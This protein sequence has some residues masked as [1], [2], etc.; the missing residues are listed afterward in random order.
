MKEY[1]HLKI[2]KKWQKEWAK[3]KVYQTKDLSKKPKFYVL[4]MFPYVSGEGIHV[5]HPKGYIATDIVS[6]MK[7]MQ[8]FNVL[9]P[10]GFD[11]FGLPAENYAIKTK[12][13]P[14]VSVAKN[15][16]R[17]KQQLE[18]IGFDYD[19][20]R[21]VNTSDP[22]F[23][24]WTQWIFLKLL[25]KGLA[26]ESNEPV[27][28]CP[29]DKTILANED[30]EN[31]KCERCGAVVEK[32]LIRQWVLRITDYAERLLDDL[33]ELDWPKSIKESQRNWIGKS[34]GSEIE[35]KLVSTRQDLVALVAGKVK[36]FTTRADTLFGAT[37]L[38]FAPEHPMVKGLQ[39]KILNWKEVLQYIVVNSKKSEIER[40]DDKKEKTG[41]ELKGVKAINPATKEE[42]PI[43]I[44]DYVLAHYGTGAIM[45][46]PAHDE[47]DFYFAKK[48]GLPIKQ[49][50]SHIVHNTSGPYAVREGIP[51]KNR[52]AVMCI[53]KHWEK[54]EYLCQEWKDF[55]EVRTL[56]SGG[57]EPGENIIDAGRREI[58]EES[59]YINAKFVKQLGGFSYIE[60]YHQRK[61]T[62]T[63]ARFRYLYY[64]LENGEQE[65]ISEIENNQH[66]FVWK[67][68]EEVVNFLNI[69]EKERI[70]EL[71]NGKEEFFTGEGYLVNSDKFDGLDSEK[72]KT[73]ITKFIGGK[74]VTNYKLRDWVFSR[75]RYWGE[76][77][78][79]LR[80][81]SEV[82]PLKE[83]DLPLKLPKVKFYEPTGTEESPLANIPSWINVKVGRKTLR[84]ESNT[85][86]Q[87]AGSSWYYLRF[88]DPKNNKALVSK[89]NEKY[90]LGSPKLG[91]GGVDLYVGG[92]EHATRHLIYARFWH[93][94]LY[95]I[96][97][98][99]TKEPFKKLQH[100]GLIIAQDGRKM[101]KRWGNI[102]N[103]DAIIS[104]FGADALRMYEM[105]MG[106]FDQSVAWSNDNIV[107]V[108]RFLER[109][110]K[111][112]SLRN[113]FLVENHSAT[114][115][116]KLLHKTIK[117]VSEDIENMNFNTAISAMMILIN[118]MEKVISTRQDLVV[119]G[120]AL[121]SPKGFAF[122]VEDFEM[123]L[124]ILSPFAPHITEEI[125]H[126]LGHKTFLVRELWPKWDENLILDEEIK[127]VVQIN[128]KVRAE[129]MI[130]VGETEEE[131]KTKALASEAIVK[132]L[133]GKTIKKAIYV[134]NRLIN[135]VI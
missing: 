34:E 23:Y 99:H 31:G 26:Y 118:E 57:I 72:A 98:V 103:P 12:T 71:F 49:V 35:F 48:Y 104:A 20:S 62:N 19:W 119:Q 100:V 101:S 131:I 120:K 122:S 112:A 95:D 38:V 93:K 36:V 66:Q 13:N 102:I 21:E 70:W 50:V 33:E 79:V 30:V 40:T 67:K 132:Y 126:S 75:Q 14:V 88:M 121:N 117:K 58:R 59:G 92:A 44:G 9:H 81:G 61:Q 54:N 97:V 51:F 82:I 94:F 108:R 91:E 107:G 3:K 39:S 134:K 43:W 86:P 64:E 114:A 135:I 123:F 15:I 90:W 27:N 80:D 52:D 96:G 60:F 127:I 6:R 73:E 18:I 77:I 69:S 4:D 129:I 53:V 55:S 29:V 24:K 113:N 25:E 106:P 37:Y 28:W 105:F 10:M 130:Q 41:V 47:H 2:E 17:Y 89:K 65:Q 1:N 78:P 116:T 7:R 76:P 74:I 68:P 16:K 124:K 125:W 32:K 46:V 111:I 11:A 115:L 110:W 133:S 56:I 45:A 22:K 84:R 109:V 87:W 8:G 42:I 5:G 83:K 85:M 128:G 63:R